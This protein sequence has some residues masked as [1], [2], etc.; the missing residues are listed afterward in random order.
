[1]VV[2]LR[3]D[4][5]AHPREAQGYL[6]RREPFVVDLPDREVGVASTRSG[7]AGA[8]E[9]GSAEQARRGDPRDPAP[10]LHGRNISHRGVRR[11]TGT[12]VASPFSMPDEILV[13]EDD[14][15]VQIALRDV[16][17]RAGYTVSTVSNGAEAIDAL[18]PFAPPCVVL[19]DLLMPGIIGG[20][21][22]EYMRSDPILARIPVAIISGSPH[23]APEGYTVFAK[24]LD[25]G[26]LLDYLRQHTS[27]RTMA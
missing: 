18:S 5:R 17:E 11:R 25:A 9:L 16:L 2:V 14:P 27:H 8:G 19:V 3:L 1:M 15:D 4:V 22:L 6:P 23:L 21:L 10:V 13:V 7:T 20:E 26:V 24:P 12:V